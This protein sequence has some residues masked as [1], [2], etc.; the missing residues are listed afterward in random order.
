M[1]DVAAENEISVERWRDLTDCA[2]R[3]QGITLLWPNDPTLK[4]RNAATLETYA[5]LDD[6][7]QA[8]RL[9]TQL[10]MTIGYL[11]NYKNRV[12]RISVHVQ[13]RSIVGAE[14]S[15]KTDRNEAMRL[16]IVLTA[17]EL[18]RDG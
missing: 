9:M 15:Y 4:P 11:K 5:P 7:A 17:Y 14:V 13:G 8:F 12:D 1:S 3:L 16:A 10:L 18:S 6:D 2:A